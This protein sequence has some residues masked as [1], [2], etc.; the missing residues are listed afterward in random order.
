MQPEADALLDAIFDNP[1]DDTPRLVYAD[2]LKEHDQEALGEFIRLQCL[3]APLM[4]DNPRRVELRQLEKKAWAAIK[5]RWPEFFELTGPTKDWFHRGFLNR[6]LR[7]DGTTYFARYP[8]WWPWF[9]ASDLCL[10]GGLAPMHLSVCPQLLARV[11]HLRIVGGD[12]SDLTVDIWGELAR[13]PRLARLRY[14]QVEGVRVSSSALHELA[15]APWLRGLRG[16]V[17]HVR[18][19]QSYSGGDYESFHAYLLDRDDER[20]IS[21]RLL[22]YAE[23]GAARFL[24]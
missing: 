15:S 16:F 14:L 6:W 1:H 9:P 17:M 19:S 10:T 7:L 4:N 13:H 22:E 24:E 21:D 18:V 8:E 3:I 11:E 20:S 23:T 12:E 5:R 2:W